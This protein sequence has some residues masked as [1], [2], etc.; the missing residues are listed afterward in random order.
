MARRVCGRVLHAF[1]LFLAAVVWVEKLDFDDLDITAL[2]VTVGELE[3]HVLAGIGC[4]M[5]MA[6]FVANAPAG[7]TT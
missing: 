1:G 2:F 4:S 5:P 3:R 7:T 6:V